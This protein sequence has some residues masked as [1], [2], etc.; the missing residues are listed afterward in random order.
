MNNDNI[1]QGLLDLVQGVNFYG[2]FLLFIGL[3]FIWLV[4]KL[5]ERS[6]KKLMQKVPTRRFIVLQ[7]TTLL[8]FSLYII[9]SVVLVIRVFNP[10]K[11]FMLAAAG[12]AAVAMGFALK[13]IAASLIGGL[14]LLFDRP[15]Q[16]GD[17]VTYGSTYGE[18]ISIGLRTVRI[19]TL[20]NDV[21]TIPN[22]RFITDTVASSNSGAANMT[23][24][25]DFHLA[26]HA[27]LEKAKALVDEVVVTCRYA[28]LKKPRSFNFT[29]V[30]IG[31]GLAIRLRCRA[32]VIDTQYESAFESD[33]VSRASQL[34]N[35]HG[36]PRPHRYVAEA[37][38]T[39]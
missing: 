32:N 4:N 2:F 21:V 14:L 38:S 10:P 18:V 20:G 36:I 31:E 37:S 7:I 33:I 16:V 30:I 5:I 34:F 3:F 12:S 25:I 35:Q 8:G 27:D 28:Y 39:G 17:R 9:G 15:F 11:E 1:G 26:V 23:V 22:S 6:G 19:Q 29:E 13:D 24:T